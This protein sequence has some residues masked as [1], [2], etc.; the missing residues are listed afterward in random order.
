MSVS[1]TRFGGPAARPAASG[2]APWEFDY[3]LPA[4]GAV[5]G[6]IYLPVLAVLFAINVI[7]TSAAGGA[8][9]VIAVAVLALCL[10]KFMSLPA[11]PP[12][13]RNAPVLLTLVALGLVGAIS[14]AY[15]HL[16]VRGAAS[17]DMWLQYLMAASIAPLLPIY[18]ALI[19]SRNMLH[20][21]LIGWSVVA[22]ISISTV[23][24][25]LAGV[26]SGEGYG[27]RQFGILGDP[28][29]WIISIFAVIYFERRNWIL[30]AVCLGLL[31][32]TGSRAPAIMAA[33]GI[34][35]SATLRPSQ[36]AGQVAM[37]IAGTGITTMGL[38]AAPLFMPFVFQRLSQTNLLDNDRIPTILY[39]LD[40]FWQSPIIGLGYNSQAFYYYNQFGPRNGQ[41]GIYIQQVD[42][43]VQIL[44]DF[45]LVGLAVFSVLA[46]FML[47][48]CFRV[49][50]STPVGIPK[51]A[52][53]EIYRTTRA[54]ACWMIPFIIVNHSAA[55][56]LPLSLMGMIFFAGT[57]MIIGLDR[58]LRDRN[59]RLGARRQGGPSAPL[60]VTI[61]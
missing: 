30:F 24:L 31:A 49:A 13:Q 26:L 56:I 48:A 39:A 47:M 16:V 61:L 10:P 21:I 41:Y 32:A 2:K 43:W 53:L 59:A 17:M 42:P 19:R 6:I 51:G 44:T 34:V 12:G 35:L 33:L 8:S 57:G 18:A 45:G 4:V 20:P 58:Q 1:Q 15:A 23:V 7:P 36:S 5:L 22:L 25:H 3:A 11:T 40:R 9:V 50:R 37:W 28:V 46:V 54:L 55:Y 29:A 27:G 38:L 14:C 52:P 60:R